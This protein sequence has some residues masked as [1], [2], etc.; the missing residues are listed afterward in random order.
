MKLEINNRN[1]WENSQTCGNN[2]PLNNQWLYKEITGEKR[3]I[4]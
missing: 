3:K 2:I 1:N 4:L